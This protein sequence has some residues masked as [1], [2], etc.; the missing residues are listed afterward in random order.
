MTH[1]VHAA[2]KS[3]HFVNVRK[4]K[5]GK[6]IEITPSNRP[7]KDKPSERLN[8]KKPTKEEDKLQKKDST[9]IS[10]KKRKSNKKP[11]QL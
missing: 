11:E 3:S 2:P 5:L 4:V 8:L 9:T 7:K 1:S 10:K 6:P